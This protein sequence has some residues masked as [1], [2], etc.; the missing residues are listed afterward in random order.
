MAMA[1][2]ALPGEVQ[3]A[4]HAAVQTA[5]GLLDLLDELHRAHLR[6]PGQGA[7]REAGGHGVQRG[8]ASASSPVTVDTRCM[9]WL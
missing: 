2:S 1:K 7:G 8:A 4:D 9:T 6:R 5:A 3:V